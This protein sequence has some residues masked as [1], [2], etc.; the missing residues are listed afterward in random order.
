MNKYLLLVCIQ[1]KDGFFRASNS[2]GIGRRRKI[3]ILLYPLLVIAFSSISF[4]MAY[5]YH[6]AY[7][8]IGVPELTITSMYLVSCAFIFL[9][10]LSSMMG[11][12]FYSKDTLFYT[13]LPVSE[14]AIVFSKLTIQYLIAL[15]INLVFLAPA[16]IIYWSVN[17]SI[18]I[19]YINGVLIL[20]LTPLVP[21]LVAAILVMAG[22]KTVSRYASRNT[23][24]VVFGILLI[25]V[26]LALQILI[27]R[28]AVDEELLTRLTQEDGM[29][30]MIS[31]NFPPSLWATKMFIGDI[32]HTVYFLLLNIFVLI[33]LYLTSRPLFRKV[34]GAFAEGGTKR[35]ANNGSLDFISKPQ[36][37]TL[38]KRQLYI[39]L[40]TPTFVLNISMLILL[41]FIL[42][43]IWSL[44]GVM[45]IQE[46][47]D[48]PLKDY[49]EYLFVFLIASPA[50]MGTFSA[51]AITREG[52]YLWQTR[53]LPISAKLDLLSRIT[54]SIVLCVTGI[55]PMT[56]LS[57]YL[58]DLN[59]GIFILGLIT[60]IIITVT[61]SVFDLIIDINRPVLN[62]TNPTHA[63][64]NNMN[65]MI[66]M[67]L[68]L[69]TGFLIYLVRSIWIPLDIIPQ[70]VVFSAF[71]A[72]IGIAAY[73]FVIK[74]GIK[75]YNAIEV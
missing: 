33:M 32:L 26:I 75:V 53:C 9:L 39:I 11:T 36:L 25:L 40:K 58:L 72:V 19:S 60:G 51:T 68:R 12:L 55:I 5:Q 48:G 16:M 22:M 18:F 45:N 6:N 70:M 73:L 3:G 50:I 47:L 65:I 31:R 37:I 52:H 66:A 4:Q 13:S 8:S 15:I 46:M 34:A 71:F 24:S 42:I 57:I 2:L 62:W 7:K 38:V 21:V 30:K 35:K 67:A 63:I 49:T 44:S 23:I 61:F 54:T 28:Q 1:I 64:K 10:A 20:L 69:V 17:D 41:P 74:S 56:A 14:K 27:S 59:T 29:L 43:I